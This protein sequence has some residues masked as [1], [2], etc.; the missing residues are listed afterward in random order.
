MADSIQFSLDPRC[1]WCWQT[2]KWVRQL[3]R[4]GTVDVRW[5]TFCLELQN[6]DKPIAEFDGERAVSG[7]ALRT[8][9]AIREHEGDAAAGRFY[10]AIG[11]RYFEG[12]QGVGEDTV[13]ASLK[14]A[15]L[16][17]AWLDKAL[18]D[19]STWA[20]VVAEHQALRSDTRSFGVPTIRL[21]GG[22]GPAI[23]GPV[24]S[25]PPA[26]DED[27][28]QLWAHI[29]WL[30]RYDNFSELK[31]DRTVEPDLEMVRTMKAKRAAEA[32]AAESA[33]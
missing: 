1:P 14:D 11:D 32:A 15:G 17:E 20:T 5:G 6:F 28:A 10:E 12:E 21:D 22:A 3:E 4:L 9:V 13:R 24:I 18:A 30:V 26:S 2:S 16:D 23:F 33:R 8:L 7:P 29:E 27:A 31:R 19:P 25:N